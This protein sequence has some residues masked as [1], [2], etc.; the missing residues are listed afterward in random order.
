MTITKKQNDTTLTILLEGK[1]D[2]V[3]SPELEKELHNFPEGITDLVFDLKDLVYISSAGLR[4]VLCAQDM[5][6]ECGGRMI[7][8]N[9]GE[10]VL[11]AFQITGFDAFL[12]IE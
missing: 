12:T 11:E 4:V 3:S 9:V 1:L 10:V 2:V 7:I 6:D 5:M 8:K